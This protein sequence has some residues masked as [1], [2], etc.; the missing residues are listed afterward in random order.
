MGIG[1]IPNARAKVLQIIN[2]IVMTCYNELCKE[3]RKVFS[4]LISFNTCLW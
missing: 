1:M 4:L 3:S 2:I